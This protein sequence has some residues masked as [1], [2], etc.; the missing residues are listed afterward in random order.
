MDIRSNETRGELLDKLHDLR[1][2]LDNCEIRCQ[3]HQGHIDELVSQKRKLLDEMRQPGYERKELLSHLSYWQDEYRRQQMR[4]VE[5]SLE[6]QRLLKEVQR[7]NQISVKLP[8]N[9]E[10]NDYGVV[11]RR[12]AEYLVEHDMRLGFIAELVVRIITEWECDPIVTMKH[13][14]SIDRLVEDAVATRPKK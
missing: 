7:L 13:A 8:V 5:L 11:T 2:K 12:I 6:N 3:V 4:S 1:D 10:N 9:L 14:R